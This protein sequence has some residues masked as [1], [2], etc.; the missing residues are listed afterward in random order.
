MI[1]ADLRDDGAATTDDLGMV[2]G[3]QL[4]LQ[5]VRLE[6]L[7]QGGG[8][9]SKLSQGLQHRGCVKTNSLQFGNLSIVT[10]FSNDRV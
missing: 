6:G 9:V 8:V 5:L 7:Q 10:R 3:I 2:V 4:N 1:R